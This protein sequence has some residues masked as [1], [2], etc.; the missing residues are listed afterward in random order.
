MELSAEIEG[1]AIGNWRN[2]KYYCRRT[3]DIYFSNVTNMVH[4]IKNCSSN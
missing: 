1:R 2:L 3:I 4:C